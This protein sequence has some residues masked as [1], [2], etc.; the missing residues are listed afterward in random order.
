MEK[1][2]IDSSVLG[3]D[4]PTNHLKQMTMNLFQTKT[5]L[6][7]QCVTTKTPRSAIRPLSWGAANFAEEALRLGPAIDVSVI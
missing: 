2:V 6:G 4:W 3:S 7:R 1:R 5:K